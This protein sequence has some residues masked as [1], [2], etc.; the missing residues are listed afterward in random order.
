SRAVQLGEGARGPRREN[1]GRA[2]CRTEAPRS[3]RASNRGPATKRAVSNPR[4]AGKSVQLGSDC[5]RARGG[6]SGPRGRG[7]APRGACSEEGRSR[8]LASRSRA[9]GE[10]RGAPSRGSG[11]RGGR[12]GLRRPCASE[13]AG[14]AGMKWKG[15]YLAMVVVGGFALSAGCLATS[16]KVFPAQAEAPVAGAPSE[17]EA[18]AEEQQ[19]H[20]ACDEGC[21]IVP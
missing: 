2:R 7:V 15:S 13:F 18:V 4:G 16:A 1:R 9:L 8:G 6:E 5:G 19:K 17:A 11:G 14:K 10:K 12:G 21:A 20:A 3:G